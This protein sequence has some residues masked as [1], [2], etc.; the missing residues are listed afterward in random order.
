MTRFVALL[1]SE[2]A[3]VAE[4]AAWALGNIAGDGPVAR[5]NVLNNNAIEGLLPLMHKS[6]PITFLRNIVWVL[7][8]LCRNKNPPPPFE[9]IQPIMPLLA[10]L[11]CHGDSQILAD[12]CW[13]I[14]YITDDD[15][16]KIQSVVDAG[17]VPCLVKL[18]DH[19]DASVIVPALRS[20]GNIV[21]GNDSQTDAVIAAGGLQR[22]SKLLQHTKANIV[23][24]AAWTVSNIAAGTP[25]QI[26]SVI[27]SGVFENI[28]YV[29]EHG[30]AKCQKEAAW[31]ITNATTSGT[32]QQVSM[33]MEKYD[34]MRS[35]CNLLAAQDARTVKVVLSGIANVFAMGER[36]GVL[37][38]MCL[39]FEEIGG[40]DKLEALQSHDNEEIYKKAFSLI[41]TFFTE[42]CN[43]ALALRFF[44]IDPFLN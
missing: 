22:M 20:V 21:T 36:M 30:D 7:S 40:L 27:E 2:S 19:P 43:F 4:Q 31:V 13:A 6:I 1:G 42:V 41:D 38:N 44:F 10:Q 29:V 35:Y 39:S 32:A 11:L 25:A 9:R 8:N 17:C 5:D 16:H 14:S 15:N 24:E 3:V 28:R 33:I 18:L 23:K 37:E 12:A 34:L 26:E